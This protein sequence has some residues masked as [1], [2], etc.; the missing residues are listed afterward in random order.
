MPE[1]FYPASSFT[2]RKNLDFGLNPA[3]MTSTED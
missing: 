1:M 3:G 2:V